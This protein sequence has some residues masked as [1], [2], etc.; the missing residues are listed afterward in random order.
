MKQVGKYIPEA[1]VSLSPPCPGLS[2]ARLKR[3][4]LCALF[5][6][7]AVALHLH[8]THVETRPVLPS[9]DGLCSVNRRLLTSHGVLSSNIP[10]LEERDHKG[11]TRNNLQE[12]RERFTS[13]NKGGITSVTQRGS[14][15]A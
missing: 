1:S 7:A 13:N 3:P 9:L 6:Q 2:H 15:P 8:E 4:P 10:F 14:S 5:S 11:V 12:N